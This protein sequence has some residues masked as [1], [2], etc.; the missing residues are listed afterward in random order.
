MGGIPTIDD[1]ARR[2]GTS[3]STVSR[4]I[5]NQAGV[6]EKTLKRV[7][8]AIHDLNYQPNHQARGLA[9]GKTR[10]I[11]VIVPQAITQVFS[12]PFFPIVIDSI[13][14]VADE[15][16]FAV[17]LWIAGTKPGGDERLRERLTKT[18]L[19]DGAV[20]VSLVDSDVIHKALIARQ[21]PC[22]L[23]GRLDQRNASYV[24]VDN[25]TGAMK[26]VGHLIGLGYKRIGTITGRL[27]I[28]AARDR[29][30]GYRRVLH[31]FGFQIDPNLIV[32]GEFQE[33][34][35]Y[36][37]MQRLIDQKVDAVF[38]ASDIMAIGAMGAIQNA[39]LRVPEDIAVVGFDDIPRATM[40]KPA[41]T[42]IRQ[43]LREF[44]EIAT[45][46]LLQQIA[47]DVDDDETETHTAGEQHKQ[48]PAQR[49][50]LPA[51]LI[52]RESCGYSLR[53]GRSLR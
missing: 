44:G 7:L 32:D 50:I 8:D 52:V 38:A 11:G 25:R 19:I 29:L 15:A 47:E 41:L 18:R 13:Y 26:A 1:V 9:M 24:D 39:G 21:T 36:N 45:R 16:E 30:D 53:T 6:S 43:P 34:V 49:V 4:V 23:I 12:D 48:M 20:I 37:V 3:R 14:K 40:V 22:V 10:V 51:E 27:D 2:S 42:T 28:G 46:L 35:A 31:E 17:M 33:E 5:N